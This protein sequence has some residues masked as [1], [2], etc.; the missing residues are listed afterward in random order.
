V[1]L[2]SIAANGAHQVT[3]CALQRLCT[4]SDERPYLTR[5]PVPTPGLSRPMA[6]LRG[7]LPPWCSRP[8]RPV[9][10]VETLGP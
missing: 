9:P 3:W 1:T 2:L 10:P 8:G 5:L 7:A 4:N 6:G